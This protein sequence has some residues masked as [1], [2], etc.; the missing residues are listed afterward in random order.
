M[1]QFKDSFPQYLLDEEMS[2][3]SDASLYFFRNMEASMTKSS[4]PS[5]TPGALEKSL[6]RIYISL[7]ELSSYLLLGIQGPSEGEH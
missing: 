1:K 6:H 5:P 4:Q 3:F 7:P 2:I